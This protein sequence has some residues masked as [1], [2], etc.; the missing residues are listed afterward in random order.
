[1]FKDRAEAGRLLA[2][3]I[4]EYKE[5]KDAIILALPRG[6]VEVGF[7]IAKALKIPMDLIITRKIGHPQNPEFAIASVDPDGR[8]TKTFEAV[9]VDPVYIRKESEKQKEEIKRRLV[10]YRGKKPP[11]NVSGQ[12]VILV[13]DGI[14]TGL[15]TLS[16]ISYLKHQNPKEIILVTPVIPYDNL[17]KFR[18]EVDELVYLEAPETFWA[19]GQFY[20]KF[21][22]VSDEEVKGFL[23]HLDNK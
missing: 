4:K 19:V 16:A 3:K 10:E 18:S 2:E 15:T 11:L 8:V 9:T 22:Q 17:R 7:E 14:A 12:T 5:N 13:D 23:K 1:M 21:P 6:G 20:Q